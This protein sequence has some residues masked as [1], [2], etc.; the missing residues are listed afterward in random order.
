MG[1]ARDEMGPSLK[2]RPAFQL[3]INFSNLEQMEHS[4]LSLLKKKSRLDV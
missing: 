3:R 1:G 4:V 2:T